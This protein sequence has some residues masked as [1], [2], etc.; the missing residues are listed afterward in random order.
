MCVHLHDH[1]ALRL[2]EPEVERCDLCPAGVVDHP[3]AWVSIRER[4]QVAQGAV[5]RAAVEE[6]D[7]QLAIVV[8]PTDQPRGALDDGSLVEDGHQDRGA[9][10]HPVTAAR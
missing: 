8:L 9:R 5:G 10:A 2:A 7:L 4:L 1:L 3:H 6:E